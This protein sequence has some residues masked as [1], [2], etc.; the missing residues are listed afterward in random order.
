MKDFHVHIYSAPGNTLNYDDFLRHQKD[1]GIDG[2]NIFS[3]SPACFQPDADKQHCW[4]AR[5][6]QLME[7]VKNVPGYN[8]VFWIDPMEADFAKQ[9][10][11]CEAQGIRAIKI[12]CSHYYPKDILPQLQQIADKNMG[13]IFHTGII[14]AEN[15]LAEYSR[16]INFE[17]L[18]KLKNARFSMAHISWPWC[19]ECISLYGRFE[20]HNKDYPDRKVTM[21]IDTT[22]GTPF[23]RRHFFLKMIYSVGYDVAHNVVW[24]TDSWLGPEYPKKFV[25]D[26]IDLDRKA[27]ADIQTMTEF[28]AYNPENEDL[29]DLAMDKNFTRFMDGK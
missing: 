8:P 19:E 23:A 16:P 5:L 21:F 3:F 26:C 4:Q 12:I 7:T 24:G 1:S 11:A 27:Y 25:Q 13:I 15:A 6:E 20:T 2:G 14:W 9:L 10:D 22:P 28:P 17:H 29:F 18:I